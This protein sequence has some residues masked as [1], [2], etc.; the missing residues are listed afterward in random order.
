MSLSLYPLRAMFTDALRERQQQ[1]IAL[2]GITSV[3]FRCLLEYVYTSQLT[4]NLGEHTNKQSTGTVF[5]E[6]GH[7]VTTM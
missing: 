1:V 7:G 2:S 5:C 3:G 6:H 4:L